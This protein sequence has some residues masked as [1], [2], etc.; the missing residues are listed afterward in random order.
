VCDRAHVMTLR[1]FQD[2][3]NN[4]VSVACDSQRATSD[5]SAAEAA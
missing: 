3:F 4:V 1:R 5:A 2:G